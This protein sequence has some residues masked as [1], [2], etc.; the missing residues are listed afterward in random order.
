MTTPSE[1]WPLLGGFVPVPV[2]PAPA[3]APRPTPVVPKPAPAP[4][5]SASTVDGV[6]FD[7]AHAGRALALVNSG[8]DEQLRSAGVLTRQL[9]VIKQGRPFA[10][11]TAFGN[12]YGIGEKTVQAVHRASQ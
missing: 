8:T 5:A 7:A 2:A 9:N 11:L 6:Y 3:P 1:A 12:A 4:A 10:D